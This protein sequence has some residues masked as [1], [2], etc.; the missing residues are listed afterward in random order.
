MDNAVYNNVTGVASFTSICTMSSSFRYSWAASGGSR[1]LSVV[2]SLS[3]TVTTPSGLLRN[4]DQWPVTVLVLALLLV[5]I[6]AASVL[7]FFDEKEK[8]KVISSF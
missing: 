2:P 5:P 3:T 7:H 4:L 6:V 8:H 1:L